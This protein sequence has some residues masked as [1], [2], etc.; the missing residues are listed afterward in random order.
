MSVFSLEDNISTV[1]KSR[2][3][4]NSMFSAK[5]AKK[6]ILDTLFPISCLSCGTPEKWICEECFA[7]IKI[8]D[9]QLC[10]LCEKVITPRGE[11]CPIC[12]KSG[13]SNLD[14]L[15]AAASYQNP[16]VKKA[17]YSLKYRFVSD[18]A[19][20]LA[21]LILKSLIAEDI[22]LPSYIIPVPLHEKRLRWRGYN[23]SRLVAEKISAELAPPFRVDILEALERKKHK[24]PQMKIKKY[25]ERLIS[26]KGIF[27][28]KVSP[29]KIKGT[30]ILLIDDIATTGATLQECA[31][32]LK[33]AGAKKVFA[34]VVARQSLK[35]K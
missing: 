13:K 23:Q 27:S 28:L 9:E 19:E 12:K 16:F 8:L 2:K 1:I 35:N 30:R 32:V 21:R 33:D 15:I 31:K 20:P 34:A 29:E 25:Q 26:V 10:P 18:L 24:R 22:P 3:T 14:G 5:F 4:K 7:A 17:V 11:L 6:I